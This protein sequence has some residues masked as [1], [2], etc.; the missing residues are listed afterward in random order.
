MISNWQRGFQLYINPRRDQVLT[1]QDNLTL[2][3]DP[4]EG[5]TAFE[6]VTV[7]DFNVS[8]LMLVIYK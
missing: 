3:Q 5:V 7:A 8:Q 1:Q 4:F 6:G 2:Q